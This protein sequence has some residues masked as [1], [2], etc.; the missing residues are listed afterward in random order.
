MAAATLEQKE[1]VAAVL[2]Y[3]RGSPNKVRR[4]L[5]TIRGKSY[6]E[7][8]MILE[9]M[10]YRACEPVLKCLVSAA[11]NAKNN[12]DMKKSSLYV[13]TCYCDEGPV[14]KRFQPRSRGRGFP[15]RKRVSHITVK[16]AERD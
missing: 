13:S 3:V 12:N 14:M 11:A 1:E 4:V 16:V 8:L 6:E 2:R 9:Y 5:D 10:P 7:A 15:I